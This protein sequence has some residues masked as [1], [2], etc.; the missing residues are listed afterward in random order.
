MSKNRHAITN[1]FFNGTDSK[2]KEEN[3]GEHLPLA[4][5]LSLEIFINI[6]LFHLIVTVLRIAIE[7][8]NVSIVIERWSLS[9]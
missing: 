1:R 8:Y 4:R 3:A 7:Q 2:D 9:E 6:K 5:N